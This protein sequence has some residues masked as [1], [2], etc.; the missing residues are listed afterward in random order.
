MS[1][2][3]RTP[4]L[5]TWIL[6]ADFRT[7]GILQLHFQYKKVSGYHS[8]LMEY[9]FLTCHIDLLSEV[10]IDRLRF[11]FLVEFITSEWE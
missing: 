11:P 8:N 6:E 10:I 1:S 2:E 3:K 7:Q 5:T 9:C 4:H